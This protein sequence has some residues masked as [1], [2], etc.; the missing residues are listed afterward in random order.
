MLDKKILL[1]EDDAGIAEVV[2]LILKDNAFDV[3]VPNDYKEI[4]KLISEVKFNLILLDMSLWG[5]DGVMIC[6]KIRSDSLNI[7]T[8]VV[9]LTAKTNASELVDNV[10][11][12]DIIEKPFEI[13]ALLTV[14]KKNIT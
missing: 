9:L 12:N 1:A 5:G 8:P 3:I 6:K 10:Y 14:V 2:S 7:Q 4:L 13:N 11:I